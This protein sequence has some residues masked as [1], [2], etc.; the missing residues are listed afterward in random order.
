MMKCRNI[1][2]FYKNKKMEYV[3]PSCTI[4][5]LLNE[6]N[7]PITENSIDENY[8]SSI[9][10][11]KRKIETI[12]P[13][14]ESDDEE[15]NE[16]IEEESGEESDYEES[17]YEESEDY[18]TDEEPVNHEDEAEMEEAINRIMGSEAFG[19][20][21]DKSPL[22]SEQE[23]KEA[24]KE[25]ERMDRVMESEKRM[26]SEFIKNWERSMKAKNV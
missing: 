7:D 6:L 24:L 8:K 1:I 5:N 2:L 23:E 4:T 12:S 15:E 22:M 21:Y 25:I 18:F 17:D 9:A 14:E 20:P 19:T 16:E 10:G 3:N 11:V 13:D 26:N